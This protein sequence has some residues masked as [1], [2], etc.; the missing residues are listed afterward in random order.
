MISCL[1]VLAGLLLAV[2]PSQS[3]ASLQ[4]ARLQFDTGKYTEAAKTLRTALSQAP[5][6][7][8]LHYWLARCHYEL[9]DFDNSVNSAERAVGIDPQNSE[10]HLWL[11]PAYGGK[12]GK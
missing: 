10:Y 11:G 7:A 2:S 5:Q 4:A 8:R 9:G 12:A 1:S 6:D 3:D